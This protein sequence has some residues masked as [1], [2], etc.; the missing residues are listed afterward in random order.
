[1]KSILTRFTKILIDKIKNKIDIF[2]LILCT[3]LFLLIFSTAVYYLLGRIVH[4]KKEVIVPN[5]VGKSVL[6]ALDIVSNVGLGLKKIGEVYNP[7]YPFSTIVVQQ[8]SAG[9]VVRK[10]RFINVILSLGGEKVFVPNLIGEE[11]RK[12]EILLRQYSLLLG[13]STYRYSLR[14]NKNIVVSQ[15]PQPSEIVEKNSFVDIEISLGPPP[16]G[17]ILVPDF[18]NKT[19]ENVYDWSSRNA[20]DLKIVEKVTDD[21]PEGVIL[22]QSIP[23][24][25]DITN[26]AVTFEVVV[27][28][29]KSIGKDKEVYN[30]EYELPFVGDTIKNVKI[31]Q[32]SDDGEYVLYNKPTSSRQKIMLYVPPRKNSKLRIFVDGILIDEK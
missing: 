29:K 15:R 10:G 11:V 32:I 14:Y 16:P 26:S 21:A 4:S 23:P 2:V 13:T 8:P 7:N 19:I 30:F 31:V 17:I 22:Q 6:E 9:M 12:A 5:I 18:I 24:D 28:K 27:S 20:I 3:F 1:M 25:T